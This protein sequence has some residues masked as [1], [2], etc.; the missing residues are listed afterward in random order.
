MTK[1]VQTMSG[2]FSNVNLEEENHEKKD[3]DDLKI[4]EK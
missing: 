4:Q 3:R 2:Y 1:H